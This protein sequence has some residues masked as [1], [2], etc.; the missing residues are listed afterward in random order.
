[1]ARIDKSVEINTTSDKVW[2]MIYWDRL[3]EWL[4]TIKKAEYTSENKDSVG[5]TAHIN[6]E[7]AGVKAE[8]DVEITEYV[9]NEKAAWRTT[10][11]NF[12]AIGLTTI[13]P[14]EAGTKIR[15]VIDYDLPYSI[16]GGIIDKLRV[17]RGIEKDIE[18]GLRKLKNILE[19]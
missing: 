1:L 16:L 10:A 13:N 18:E 9:K 6:A 19:K 3:P 15:F 2:E 12:T 7:A 8:W 17:G 5:A 11:G 4:G 14:T